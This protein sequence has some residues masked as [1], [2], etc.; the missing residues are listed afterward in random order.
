MEIKI[1]PIKISLFILLWTNEKSLDDVTIQTKDIE[2]TPPKRFKLSS[3]LR[4][5]DL[6]CGFGGFHLAMKNPCECHNE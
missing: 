2:Q 6:F 5:V 4:F 1:C 3:K